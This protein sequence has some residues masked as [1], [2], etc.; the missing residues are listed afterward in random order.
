MYNTLNG[1]YWESNRPGNNIRISASEIRSVFYLGS[2]EINKENYFIN[3]ESIVSIEVRNDSPNKVYLTM[4]EGTR[5]VNLHTFIGQLHSLPSERNRIYFINDR[6]IE[7][8]KEFY[9]QEDQI[10]EVNT[11]LKANI[12]GTDIELKVIRILTESKEFF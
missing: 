9:I 6:F 3:P 1:T 7:N 8:P 2:V 4:P 11:E 12:E 5:F 10:R